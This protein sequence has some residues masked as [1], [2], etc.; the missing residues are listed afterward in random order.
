LFLTAAAIAM[1]NSTSAADN[2]D[3]FEARVFTDGDFKLPY[4]LV[5]P[6]GYDAKQKYP[7][8]IFLHG[9]GERGEDNEKQLVHGMND[10][11][12]DEI[13]TKYPAF[14]IA[15]PCPRD[16]AWGGIRRRA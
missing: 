11:A 9:A 2:R 16:E 6:K 15:P 10:F 8:V 3:R 4:R 7:L 5:K 12:S 1:P 13:M 14:V